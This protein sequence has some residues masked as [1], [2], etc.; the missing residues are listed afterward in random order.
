MSREPIG[1]FS[2]PPPASRPS[3]PLIPPIEL[4]AVYRMT[5]PASADAILAGEAP[6][7]V[8]AR[9]GHPN[10]ADLAAKCSFLHGAEAGI[11]CATGMAA[12]AAAVLALVETG[13]EIVLSDELYGK[14]VQ[15]L[16]TEMSRLGITGTL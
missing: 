7:Y 12:L 3:A 5:D 15:L 14:S 10:A 13:D 8:Y 11:V 6:G 9:D 1:N 4:S 16:R 2:A